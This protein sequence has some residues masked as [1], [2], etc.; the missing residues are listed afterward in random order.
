[1]LTEQKGFVRSGVWVCN[2]FEYHVFRT[3]LQC[4]EF[5]SGLP[6]SLL[7]LPVVI[8]LFAVAFCSFPF[9]LFLKPRAFLVSATQVALD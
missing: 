5:E 7:L 9:R 2:R 4:S 1:M 6:L 3:R 8:Y